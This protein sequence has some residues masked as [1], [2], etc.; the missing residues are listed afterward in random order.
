VA[1]DYTRYGD[2]KAD[3]AA[4]VLELIGP[5]RARYEELSADPGAVTEVLRAGAER[6]EAVA[7]V[8]LA[9]AMDAIGLLPR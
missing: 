9:R 1:G 6:A 2:L 4:A 3:T 7:A 5:I 8:T